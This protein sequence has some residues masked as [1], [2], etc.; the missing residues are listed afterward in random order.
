MFYEGLFDDASSFDQRFVTDETRLREIVSALRTL[1]QKIVLTS[2][3]FD[4][5]HEGHSRYL[6]AARGFG[7]FLIVGVDSDAKVQA[8]KGRHRPAVPEM[9][10]LRMVTHQR[11]VGLVTLKRE[12]DPK[13]H[14][15][16]LVRPDILVATAE[17]Y[18]PEEIAELESKYCGRVEVLERM[19]TVSTSARLRRIQLGAI[20]SPA[21]RP[22]TPD[23]R[24]KQILL[25]LPVLTSAFESFLDR[26]NDASE[27]LILGRGFAD[28][29]P[30]IRKDIRALDPD[31][32]ADYLRHSRPSTVVTVVEPADLP[33]AVHADELTVPDDALMR[34]VIEAHDLAARTKVTFDPVF[35]F[36]DREWSRAGRPADHDGAVSTD[37]LAR[38]Y[39]ALA[40]AL[41]SRSSDWWRRV[42]AVIVGENG[43]IDEA[44]NHHLPTEYAPYI[45]GDP[46]N[47]FR[48][49]D[50]ADLST[51]I[52]A[53]ASLI[54]RAARKGVSL[55]G[56]DLYV[57]TFP[58]PSCA[59]LIAESG[60]RRCFFTGPY[61]VLEGDHV[62]RSAGVELIWVD[63]T[64]PP[65]P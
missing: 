25:Y 1:G 45:D 55:E 54:G 42:G 31:R 7:N 35:L 49:G 24:D 32:A 40:Q 44:W 9:E 41:A 39:T 30:V 51:A 56:T 64:T 47:N 6:E 15:I 4:I 27:I 58:C 20:D 16:K 37:E 61:S 48:R 65:T 34:D 60:I 8:R 43:V 17:T 2:G 10:R 36:W 19:S 38:E 3:S 57:T 62:L 46:R 33:D 22:H 11:G 50:R 23:N 5:L 52:H 14:L 18:T 53:E 63:T 59:R 13:W 21:A 28:A 26:H 29:F 12:T